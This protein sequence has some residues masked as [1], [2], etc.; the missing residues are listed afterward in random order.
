M[1]GLETNLSSKIKPA[2]LYLLKILILAVVIHLAARLG[3]SM[4]YVQVNTSPVWPPAGIALAALLLFGPE[5]WPGITLGV[6]LGS[7]LTKAPL[8]LAAGLSLGNTLEALAA[9]Y[10]LDRI[11]G[12]HREIDRIRD[13]VGLALVSLA[14][15]T[16]GATL[17]TTTLMLTGNGIWPNFWGIWFTWWIGDLLGALVVAPLLL[18]WAF[19]STARANRRTYLEGATL[20]VLV[21]AFTW[22]V[23]S[24]L[25]PIGIFHQAMIYVIFPFVIWA[26]LR[27][28]QRGATIAITI[29]SG[30]AIWGTSQGI[31]PFSLESKNDSL[32]ILQTFMAVV[33]LTALILAAATIERRKATDA[34]RQR[35]DDLAT[36]NDSSKSFLDNFEITNIFQTICRLA[37]TRLGLDVAWIETKDQSEEEP[38]RVVV[39][40][41]SLRFVKNLIEKW[42]ELGSPQILTS[43]VI[44][45]LGDIVAPDDSR[46][47]VYQA[48]AVFPLLFSNRLIG[49]LQ[50]LSQHNGFFTNDNQ[51]LLQSYANLAAVAI[52][53]TLLFDE[54]RR[55]NKQLHG[56][57]QRLMK[58][59]EEER[60]HLSRE[61]HDESGQLLTALTF[62]LGLL[63]RSLNQPGTLRERIEELKTT[64]NQIQD[65]LH[66][67]AVNLRPA[68]LDHLGL[69]TT[70]QQ[71][72][73]EFN[74]QY[75]IPV[76][77]EAVGL[78]GK[79]LPIEVE[80]AF[81]RI[82]QESLTN[83]VL[84]AQA[85]R[86]DILLNL[87]NQN[88][89]MIVED[90]GIGF[91]PGSPGLEDHLGL[92]GMRER[93]E[94]LGGSFVIES[95]PGKGTTIKA[96]VPC[97][98]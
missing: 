74:R 62:Q 47:P 35:V 13:V 67:L 95:S 55:S 77:F 19:F 16:I 65:N 89:V 60:L 68:S 14:C 96:E 51:I 45:D 86:V 5:M 40:G 56:L 59:Q 9:Y 92:F 38:A 48:Y 76:D 7:L 44:K 80:T 83:V 88:V 2:L 10:C 18:T 32:V 24:S 39:Y 61:L 31:G 52:Q 8:N 82:V 1:P 85:G 25:P 37:V 81:F 4:A 58:A 91:T 73:G 57:S 12:F 53:N 90:D 33:T 42:P 28:G 30:I 78:G 84:H 49:T 64:A 66:K 22:F 15:T 98:D 3:L 21:A 63:E 41:T 97:H 94:M 34:L 23:F 29:V 20:L 87:H 72:I 17:G 75:G 11:V 93:I 46:D 26:A 43:P 79:R 70:L 27:F 71:F 54:V 50:L 6:L 69:V 36:L